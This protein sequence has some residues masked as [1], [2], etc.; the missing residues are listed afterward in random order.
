M[1]FEQRRDHPRHRG[2]A[3]GA[4]HVDG[5]ETA[6][7]QA[8]RRGQLPHPVEAEPPADRFQ[9]V[10][11]GPGRSPPGAF[12]GQRHGSGSPGR[13]VPTGSAPACRA[14]PRPPR[15]APWRRSPRSRVCAR[16]GRSRGQLLAPLAEP[17]LDRGGVERVGGEHPDRADRGDRFRADPVEGEAGEAADELR[18]RHPVDHRGQHRFG[19]H[20]DQVA[21]GAQAAGQGDLFGDLL[22]GLLVE[23]R[24]VGGGEGV[25]AR[26]PSRAGWKDQSSSVTNGIVGWSSASTRSSA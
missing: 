11:I 9:R 14:L 5:G 4:D 17:I 15:R 13:R 8:Q 18:G 24:G 7:R 25:T 16:R 12:S 22:L 20:A 19:R 23:E 6:L 2:L 1:R 3:V 10:E 26:W 21:P